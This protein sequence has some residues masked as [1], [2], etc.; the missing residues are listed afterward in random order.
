MRRSASENIFTICN[1]K[2]TKISSINLKE[3]PW[4]AI[5]LVLHVD[6]TEAK[7]RWKAF[8]IPI[9]EGERGEEIIEERSWS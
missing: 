1:R 4:E 9:L 7:K 3:N 5:A 2:I 8:G 6:A